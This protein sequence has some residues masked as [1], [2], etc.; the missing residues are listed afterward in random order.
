MLRTLRGSN[1]EEDHLSDGQPLRILI[2]EDDPADVFLLKQALLRQAPCTFRVLGT[3]T[4]AI[5]FIDSTDQNRHPFEPDLVILDVNLPGLDGGGVL[6]HLRANRE[7][8]LTVVIVLSSLP[9][10]I[11][12]I[13]VPWADAYFTKPMDLDDYLALGDDIL[14]CYRD[15]LTDS[16]KVVPLL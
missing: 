13:R 2:V 9:S 8:C 1:G 7:T 4:S 16:G 5:E 3:G 10:D 14:K 6:T 11:Q 15:V 12:E